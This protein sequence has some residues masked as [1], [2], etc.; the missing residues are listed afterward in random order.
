[1]QDFDSVDFFTDRELVDDPY[2]YYEHLYS[3]CPVQHLDTRDGVVAVTGYDEA[4]EVFREHE[5]FSACNT[6]SGPFLPITRPLVGD[7]VSETIEACRHMFPGNEDMVTMDQPQHTQERALLM[8]VITPKRLKDNEEFMSR[9]ADEQLEEILPLGKCE[10]IN[11]YAQPF[12]MLAVADVLGVPEEDHDTFR[13]GFGLRAG[14]PSSISL[15]GA[16]G[17]YDIQG[18]KWL[19]EWFYDYLQAR[20]NDPRHD[21]L[22]D[23][24][25][26][27][28]PDGSTPPMNAIVRTATFLFS[29]GQ[30]TTARL[31]ATGLKILADQPE[32][33]DQL[34]ANPELIPNFVEEALRM[35]SP[36]KADSRL[37]RRAATIGGVDVAAGD[38]VVLL[39][40]AANRD[41]RRFESPNE[42]RADRPNAKEHIAFGRGIHSCPGAPLARAEGRITFEV[43]LNRM[44]NLRISRGAP[45]PPGCPPVPPRADVG[46]PRAARTAHRIRPGL[47]ALLITKEGRTRGEVGRTGRLH[48]WGGARTGT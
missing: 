48:Q 26:A 42:F 9:L 35:E 34:R 38:T 46:A 21:V 39:L 12:S 11:A 3:K 18:S 30:E 45:R 25:L 33:Q 15:G 10:F 27:K 4:N 14:K 28:Y 19:D 24:A 5:L 8:R 13:E 29:A 6:T 43:I 47:T 41:P 7:D 17:Q 1:M 16:S 22:T 31:L 20:R 44:R 23:L 40:G 36:T 2:P 37:A 32:L